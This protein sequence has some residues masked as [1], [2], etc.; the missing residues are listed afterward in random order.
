M[1]FPSLSLF[2]LSPFLF[3][4]RLFGFENQDLRRFLEGIRSR[5]NFGGICKGRKGKGKEKLVEGRWYG[6]RGS[7]TVRPVMVSF[8]HFLRMRMDAGWM[9]VLMVGDACNSP[10]SMQMG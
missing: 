2:S 3:L 1:Y 4:L 7:F 10:Y 6:F 9:E 8:L 5:G